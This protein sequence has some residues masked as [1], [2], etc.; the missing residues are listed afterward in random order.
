MLARSSIALIRTRPFGEGWFGTDPT[1][2][3]DCR[4]QSPVVDHLIRTREWGW[5]YSEAVRGQRTWT[6]M[7][8]KA[9]EAGL[10]LSFCPSVFPFSCVRR[11]GGGYDGVDGSKKGSREGETRKR[12]NCQ[13]AE[14]V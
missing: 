13:W 8:I 5:W 10:V 14:T 9:F 12:D 1:H 3:Y 11:D 6:R 7:S 2:Y 4:L